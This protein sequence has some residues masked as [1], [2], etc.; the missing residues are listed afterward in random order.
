MKSNTFLTILLG[1][2][3]AL[4][5]WYCIW[6]VYQTRALRKL[7]GEVVQM[8]NHRQTLQAITG[9]CV[10]YAETNASIDPILQSMGVT[11]PN[12]NKK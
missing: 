6:Y 7:E 2:S 10:K 1:A 12:R 8:N 3:L 9:V 5:M 11:L 4:S